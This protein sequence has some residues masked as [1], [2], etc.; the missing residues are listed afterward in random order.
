[1][2]PIV[3]EQNK[4]ILNDQPLLIKTLKAAWYS[5]TDTI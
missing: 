1:M 4:I 3:L 2:L 5:T